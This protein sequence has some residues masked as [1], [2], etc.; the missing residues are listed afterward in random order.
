MN[1]MRQVAVTTGVTNP[2][3]LSGSAF[4]Y[5][6]VPIQVS[7]GV[8][9]SAAGTF[10]TIYAGSRLIAEEFPPYVAASYP[11]VPDTVYF[12]FVALPQERLVVAARNPTGGTV[13]FYLAAEMQQVR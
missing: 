10:V 7:M 5:P 3:L 11:V 8:N 2:N 4:E 9:A 12:N 13:T 6:Q 1:I